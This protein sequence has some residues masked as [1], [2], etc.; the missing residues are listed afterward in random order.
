MNTL[1]IHTGTVHERREAWNAGE[2]LGLTGR[3]R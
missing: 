2:W 3:A 1:P